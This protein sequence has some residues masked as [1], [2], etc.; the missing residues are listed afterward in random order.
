MKT[1]ELKIFALQRNEEMRADSLCLVIFSTPFNVHINA[2][3]DQMKMKTSRRNVGARVE[4][5]SVNSLRVF[6]YNFYITG[7]QIP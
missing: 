2:N 3:E 4:S 5:L 1:A 6:N 7:N